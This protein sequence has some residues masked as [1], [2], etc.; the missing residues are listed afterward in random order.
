[1]LGYYG[2]KDELL[3]RLSE[4][5]PAR[6]Q[7]LTGPRQVG[8]TT[9]LLDIAERWGEFGVY[10]AGDAPEA[11]LPGWWE[12][13]WRRVVDLAR[14]GRALL[15]VDEVQYLPQ[16][17][18]L[19]KSAIDEA[20][21]LDLPLHVVISGS[22]ALAVNTGARETMAGRFERLVLRQWTPRDMA[23][24]FGLEQDEAV[25]RYVRFGSFP[26]STGIIDDLPRW[27]SYVRDSIMDPAIGRDLMA[28]QPVRKPALLRQV[29]AVATGHPA[30]V[31]SLQK[32][33]G[34]LSESGTSE[35]IAHYLQLLDEAYLVSA[36]PKH[37]SKEI[38][39]RASP[40]KL[41]A[42]NNAL[43]AAALSSHPPTSADNPELWGR[44]VENAVIASAIAAGQTVHYWRE[45][46]NEVDAVCSG[47]WGNWAIEVKCGSYTTKDLAGLLEFCR[48]YPE[49]RPL[50][51]C[52]QGN[53]DG[54]RRLGAECMTREDF[55]W[56]GL[57]ADR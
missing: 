16:W 30:E 2:T 50:V 37:S 42:L 40:P 48:R 1:M 26:G 39:R 47:S 15:L 21:R 49:F 57:G 9:M 31:I 19:I 51:V 7:V 45:E 27:R 53:E 17:S 20:Y 28:L 22:A 24:A 43:L 23:R 35:T 33:A 4:Q 8:K 6:V 46:P 56:N 38:R 55:L 14:R 13:Q 52:T 12:A 29:Y 34:S 25:E 3:R 10:L 11:A 54:A 36:L 32:I 5:P 44:W 41:V 18:R